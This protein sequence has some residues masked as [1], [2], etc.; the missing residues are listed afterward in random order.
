MNHQKKRFE[1]YGVACENTAR[2]KLPSVYYGTF[3]NKMVIAS[4]PEAIPPS[5]TFGQHS[6]R[7]AHAMGNNIRVPLYTEGG[8]EERR[9]EAGGVLN[10]SREGNGDAAAEVLG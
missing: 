8:R 2:W 7:Q 4:S 10:T 1:S 6:M 9:K 5:V 3:S